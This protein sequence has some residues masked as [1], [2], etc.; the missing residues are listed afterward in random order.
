TILP[1]LL[2]PPYVLEPLRAWALLALLVAAVSHS[3]SQRRRQRRLQIRQQLQRRVRRRALQIRRINEAL[4]REITRRQATQQR[5]TRAETHLQ[6]LAQRMQL[7][8]IRKDID[9]VITYANEAFCS[10][11]GRSVDEVIGATDFDL[12]PPALADAYRLDDER[13]MQS[14]QPVDHIESHP[15]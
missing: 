11:L 12:Y 14:G 1:Y 7:Q 2:R 10:G 5:L 13:V 3:A 9:G 15:T 4:R 6:S 8:V